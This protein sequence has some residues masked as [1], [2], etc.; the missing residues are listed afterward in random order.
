[1]ASH[2]RNVVRFEDSEGRTHCGAITLNEGLEISGS[3]VELLSRDPFDGDVML[4]GKT[5]VIKKVCFKFLVNESA[6]RNDCYQQLLA[7]VPKPPI[8]LCIAINYAAHS[9]ESGISI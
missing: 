8:F 5:S 6:N 2:I 1:M 7:P 3:V 9:K 4:S